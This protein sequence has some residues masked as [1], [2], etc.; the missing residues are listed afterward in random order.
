MPR[1]PTIDDI[2]RVA[3]QPDFTV[4][5]FRG[6]LAPQALKHLGRTVERTADM[7]R[8]FHDEIEE[9]RAM[10]A[11]VELRRRQN[12]MTVG[13]SGYARLR[14]GAA[15]HE[16]VF[17][18]Y[19]DLHKSVT[20]D[21]SKN[22]SP[23]ARAMFQQ[24]ATSERENFEA[25]FLT[26]AMRED[27]SHTDEIFKS[28]TAMHAE[29][30]SAIYDNPELV[31]RERAAQQANIARY[32][33]KTGVRDPAVVEHITQQS[34]A[35]GHESIIRA[36][37]ATNNTAAAKQYLDGVK[38]EIPTTTEKAL[39]TLLKPA[40]ADQAG[41]G[42]AEKMFEMYRSGKGALAIQQEKL[43][44]TEGMSPETLRVADNIY[45][46][47]VT[48]V[49]KDTKKAKGALL[50]RAMG[51]ETITESQIAEVAQTNPALAATL[52]KQLDALKKGSV[53]GKPASL[54]SMSI[55]ARTMDKIRNGEIES[56]EEIGELAGV[57]KNADVK[58]LI[59]AFNSRENAANKF[60]IP[61]TLIDAGRPKGANTTANKEAYKGFIEQKLQDWKDQ[62]PGR[63]PTPE[64]QR[65][66]IQSAGEEHVEV[67]K[68]WFNS[69]TP[70]YKLGE[71]AKTYPR[72]YEQ[73]LPDATSEERADAYNFVSG[74][75]ASKRRGD[76][77]YSEAELLEIW[78]NKDTIIK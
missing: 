52:R 26:H 37:I 19:Q 50:L 24:K 57:L 53:D 63:V 54:S 23:R 7:V 71:G 55:Y 42:V 72:R 39:N 9:K 33:E 8:E 40:I 22:L 30:M 27:I 56:A 34:L 78:R 36:Y 41:R 29:T 28:Q 77:S 15:T 76:V 60:K 45:G 43:K 32:L 35:A 17:K 65:A 47:L 6:D 59:S 3:P 66:I 20:E 64:E 46:D 4:A 51:G 38:H 68:Y 61:K 74:Y 11:V 75:N 18:K 5:Q 1:L 62:N 14:N 31:L 21:L 10:E 16:G 70:A 25:G 69:E 49:D 67:N 44:L 2:N 73:L 48:A 58:S 13:E 12:L